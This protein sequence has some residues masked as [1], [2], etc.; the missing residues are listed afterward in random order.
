MDIVQSVIFPIIAG[1]LGAFVLSKLRNQSGHEIKIVLIGA[2]SGLVLS[3]LFQKIDSIPDGLNKFIIPLA[4]LG[5]AGGYVFICRTV[6]H[7]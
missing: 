5:G 7:C 3:P 6:W 2:L 4:V 1:A